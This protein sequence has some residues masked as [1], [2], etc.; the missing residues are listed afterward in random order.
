MLRRYGLL[1]GMIL[2]VM[3][4]V[5]DATAQKASVFTRKREIQK[6]TYGIQLTGGGSMYFMNDVN[7]Y[8]MWASGQDAND[9]DAA[10]GIEGGFAIL[11]RSTENFR[12]V[13]GFNA[14]GQDRS[15]IEWNVENNPIS[16]EIEQTISGNEIYVQ[17]NYA[18]E[19]FDFLDLHFLAGPAVY[20]GYLDYSASTGQS[21]ANAKGRALG[22]R[23]GLGAQLMLGENFGLNFD[24]GYRYA[25]I[26]EVTWEDR[27]GTPQVVYF[28]GSN[29][30]LEVEL[31]GAFVEIGARIYFEPVTDWVRF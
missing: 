28:G 14:L 27:N 22:V 18:L 25:K 3:L 2:T 1:A 17:G 19:F 30:R 10:F 6:H 9:E 5:Q 7:D 12:L 13:I 16:Q 24:L 8:T 29:R 15:Y 11:Y 4:L 31:S 21:F 23:L 26:S 20:S